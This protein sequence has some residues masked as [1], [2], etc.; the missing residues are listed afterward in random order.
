MLHMAADS[1]I[2]P[3]SEQWASVGLQSPAFNQLC[4]RLRAGLAAVTTSIARLQAFSKSV[5]VSTLV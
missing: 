4:E 5:S 3:P 1:V 2:A